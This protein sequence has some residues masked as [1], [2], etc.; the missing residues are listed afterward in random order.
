[1][2]ELLAGLNRSFEE[3]RSRILGKSPLPSV[4]EAFAILRGEDSRKKIMLKDDHV[5]HL[6]L[7]VSALAVRTTENQKSRPT[8]DHCQKIGH[9]KDSCWKLHG[10]PADWKPKK[11]KGKGYMAETM[12][13]SDSVASSNVTSSNGDKFDQ[14][15]ELLTSLQPSHKQPTTT[16]VKRGNFSRALATIKTLSS[17]KCWIIDSGASDHMTDDI[18]MFS[19]YTV[20][21]TPITVK[22]ADATNSWVAGFGSIT[23][24]SQLT[25]K[26]V[27]HV[28]KLRCNLISVSTL[29][30]DEKCHAD[31]F[32]YHCVFQELLTGKTIGYAREH[33]GLYYLDSNNFSSNIPRIVTCN[34]VSL[35]RIST[36]ELW[37]Q[38]LGHPSFHYMSKMFPDIFPNKDVSQFMCD[39]C[40]IAK[41]HR[42]PFPCT[43][44]R[45]SHPFKI[46]HSDLWGPSRITNRTNSKWF[47]TF[48]DDHTS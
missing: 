42:L 17:G 35:P 3:V 43:P 1:M 25:L 32:A 44:Y 39:T 21:K 33:E 10:K 41:H 22:I 37:H 47:I 5:A 29:A 2:F 19:S 18:S 11:G 28:T 16:V 46:I 26:N 45:A 4:R 31:F 7:E 38:R 20:D 23:I 40:E 12:K 27:L 15:L 30:K 48:I 36:L 9:T 6:P 34:T 14:I 24:S 13:D 8:C